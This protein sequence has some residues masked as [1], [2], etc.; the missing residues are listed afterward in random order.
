MLKKNLLI[1]YS[2]VFDKTSKADEILAMRAKN[3]CKA[4]LHIKK[5]D[6]KSAGA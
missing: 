2:P 1:M 4:E 3:W 6:A 5:Y